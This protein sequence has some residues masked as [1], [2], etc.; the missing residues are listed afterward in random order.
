MDGACLVC[1]VDN[2]SVLVVHG[3]GPEAEIAPQIKRLGNMFGTQFIPHRVRH[4]DRKARVENAFGYVMKNFLSARQF[5]DWTDLNNQ[6]LDWCE[7]VANKRIKRAL[8]MSADQ[9]YLMEKPFLI[10]VPDYIPSVYESAYRVVDTQGYISL[11]T[12]RYSVPYKLIGKK[13]EVQKHFEDV[14]VYHKNQLAAEHKREI[15]HRE[16]RITNASHRS[17]RLKSKSFCRPSKE[18]RMLVG[19]SGTLDNYVRQLKKRSHGRGMVKLR[20]LLELKR[21]YP[22]QAFDDGVEKALKFGL[23]DLSRPENVILS[24]IAGDYFKL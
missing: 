21:T 3:A 14:L 23:Y 2:T 12:N 16:K 6:A 20:R 4:P 11:D 15:Q 19:E 5:S 9:A 17:P 7:T 24:F 22:K 8:G 10:P 18:E 13:V 1:T